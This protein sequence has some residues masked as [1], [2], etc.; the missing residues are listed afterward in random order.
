MCVCMC[1]F[2]SVCSGTR[3]YNMRLCMC[4]RIGNEP[5]CVSVLTMEAR[6]YNNNNK[7]NNAFCITMT[8]PI[9]TLAG[10]TDPL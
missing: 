10:K 2:V 6:T 4:Q 5:I 9:R 7:N 3:P 1:V 8:S